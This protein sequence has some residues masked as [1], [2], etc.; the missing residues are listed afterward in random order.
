MAEDFNLIGVQ[1]SGIVGRSHGALG[2]V[3]VAGAVAWASW[4]MGVQIGGGASVADWKLDGV[5]LAGLANVV[6]E[7]AANGVQ[8]SSAVNYAP[9][10]RGAQIGLVNVAR[11][12]AGVQV[13][14][15]NLIGRRV[16]PVFNVGVDRCDD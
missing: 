3:Q 10:L 9:C 1:V 8:I 15:I 7:E 11:Q 4:P 16:T 12:A 2:G 13:G 5:Q 6:V 14:L